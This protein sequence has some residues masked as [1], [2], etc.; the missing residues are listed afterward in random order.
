MAKCCLDP[1]ICA[2]LSDRPQGEA[3]RHRCG[4]C[5]SGPSHN[6]ATRTIRLP[7]V[8]G[9]TLWYLWLKN[10]WQAYGS[11]QDLAGISLQRQTL[12][13]RKPSKHMEIVNDYKPF[14]YALVGSIG[15]SPHWKQW[16]AFLHWTQSVDMSTADVHGSHACCHGWSWSAAG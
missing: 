9:M 4:Q 7:D 8:T 2:L 14:L 11:R 6:S 16:R 10:A 5:F 13:P 3:L 15:F 12:V 1:S